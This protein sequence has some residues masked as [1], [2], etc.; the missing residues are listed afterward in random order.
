MSCYLV[1]GAAGFIGSHLVD[2]LID[3]GHA[4]R[5]LDDLSSGRRDN[6]RAGVEFIKGDVTDADVVGPAFDG[7]EGCFHLAAI[8]SIERGNRDW[9]RT[10]QVNLSGTINVFDAARRRRGIADAPVPVVYASSAAVYGNQGPAPAAEQGC[11][12]PLSAYGADKRACELHARAAGLTHGLRTVGLRFFNIYGAR[13]DP[14]SPYSG[15]IAIFLDR[16]QR[17][18]PIEIFGDGR[19]VRDFTY[20]ADAVS[21]LR[22]A[23]PAASASAPLF[24][25]CTGRGTTVRRLAET[26]ADLCQT[27]LV[28][29]Y[30]PA[31]CAEVPVSVGDPRWAAEEL[32]FRARADLLDGLAA[33][34]DALAGR[35]RAAS[36]ALA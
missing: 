24:N 11:T 35:R 2:S 12:A 19:Q 7:V 27:E 3:D 9:L 17:G 10:H 31:R 6:L 18:E 15:V 25:V 13:Q 36:P 29:R 8:A 16:L 21:A 14:R 4:V 30:R 33:T 23:M 1:T 26:I 32:G 20:I 28:I 22:R 5:V 34:L